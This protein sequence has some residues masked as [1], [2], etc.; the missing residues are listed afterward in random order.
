[1]ALPRR[2]SV[3]TVASLLLE[4]PYRF[5]FHQAVKLLEYLHPDAVPFGETVSPDKEVVAVKS[6][7]YLEA[8]ASDIYALHLPASLHI[9]PT[10]L[11]V[12]F[13]GIAGIQG[14]LPF[15]YTEMMIQRIRNGDTSLKDFL[16][17]FNHRLIAILHRIR[18]QYMIS[19]NTVTPEKT[20]IATGLK[21]FIG[22]GIP[23]LQNRL[24][25]PDRSLLN[26]AGLYWCHPHSAEGLVRILEGYFKVPVTVERCVGKWRPIQKEQVTRLGKGGQWQVLG[27][28][29]TL[30]TRAWDQ[31]NNFILHCG[32]FTAE[33]LDPFLPM[34][35]KFPQLQSLTSLYAGAYQDFSVRYK[36]TSPPS[37]HLGKKSYLGWRAWLGKS[38]KSGDD[39]R[40]QESETRSQE[41]CP[42]P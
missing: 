10:T 25:L 27:Q 37:T 42:A 40:I 16:D 8:L 1:M 33:E 30:G 2:Q 4:E 20:E 39:V 9:T 28:S 13:M 12:N 5:E 7:V 15:P 17:I 38:L 34:G 21:S 31:A 6:R 23:T 29:A 41:N 14:P 11:E 36:V 24:D 3:P 18:K 22:I 35:K 19:L 32:P 26:Y